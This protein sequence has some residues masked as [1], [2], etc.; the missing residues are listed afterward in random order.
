MKNFQYYVEAGAGADALGAN[1]SSIAAINDTKKEFYNFVG[2]DDTVAQARAAGSVGKA[3]FSYN[4]ATDPL[5]TTGSV[6]LAIPANNTQGDSE[7]LFGTL[8]SNADVTLQLPACTVI[9]PKSAVEKTGPT[10]F[11]VTLED[12]TTFNIVRAQGGAVTSNAL[13]HNGPMGG[14]ERASRLAGRF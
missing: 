5:D 3:T 14:R 1:F 9:V 13:G 11:L 4:L 10:E 8:S 2:R 6:T 12:R 7:T